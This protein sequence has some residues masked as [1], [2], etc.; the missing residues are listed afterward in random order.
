MRTVCLCTPLEDPER[1]ARAQAHFAERG[2]HA[3]FVWG[4]HKST[5][6][7]ITTHD[8]MVDRGPGSPDEGVPYQ[9]GPHPTNIW[10]GHWMIWN[11]LLLSREDA[12]F[13]LECD[14]KFPEDWVTA[15]RAALMLAPKNYDLIYMGSCC[16]NGRPKTPV[17][18]DWAAHGAL[19]QAQNPPPPGMFGPT[20]GLYQLHGTAPQCNHAYVVTR[21]AARILV[22]TLRKVWAPV[23]I[24]QASECWGDRLPRSP[25]PVQAPERRLNVYTVLPRIVDQWDTEIGA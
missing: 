13:V 21:A 7:L 17:V 12:W 4:L 22:Q 18:I 10:I 14:A 24:Q 23:D 20:Y 19:F 5:S 25:D 1:Y 11:A 3:E 2:V 6:G 8:Y 15:F 9:I 16:T